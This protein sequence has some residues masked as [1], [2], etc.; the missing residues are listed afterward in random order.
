M[1][2][3]D[4]DPGG[5]KKWMFY[6]IMKEFNCKA[7]STWSKCGRAKRPSRT[8]ILSPEKEEK[9]SQLDYIIGPRRRDDEV[10][11]C[12]DVRTWA[13]WDHYAIFARIQDEEQTKKQKERERSAQCGHQRQTSN[14]L[15]SV[16]R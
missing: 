5:F 15:N 13:T 7:T 1:L 12:N 6:G 8:N 11:V 9:T 4:K 10:H 14:K 3:R 2:A 16:K